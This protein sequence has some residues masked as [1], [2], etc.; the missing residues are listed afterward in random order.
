MGTITITKIE[1]NQ[2][3]KEAQAY[4]KIVDLVEPD[5]FIAPPVR[6]KKKVLSEFKKTGLYSKAFL[7]DLAE[8]LGNS[9][10]VC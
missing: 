10:V 4:R 5:L 3:K 9:L 6:S 1:Y 2:L 7:K 8:G